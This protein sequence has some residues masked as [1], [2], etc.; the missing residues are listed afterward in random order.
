MV[1][2]QCEFRLDIIRTKA[3]RQLA[4]LTSGSQYP[5]HTIQHH[6]GIFSRSSFMTVSFR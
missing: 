1:Y 5:Q 2:F 4:P 3:L 6:A